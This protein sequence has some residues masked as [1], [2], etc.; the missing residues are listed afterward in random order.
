MVVYT[1][2]QK[3]RLCKN[4]VRLNTPIVTIK[5]YIQPNPFV[6]INFVCTY[7]FNVLITPMA[8]GIKLSVCNIMEFIVILEYLVE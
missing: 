5:R 3:L 1:L 2:S 6:C 7:F 4:D 8:F